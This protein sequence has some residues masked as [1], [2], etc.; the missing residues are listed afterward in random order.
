MEHRDLHVLLLQPLLEVVRPRLLELVFVLV[1]LRS[2]A[3]ACRMA[4]K[5][6]TPTI[7]FWAKSRFWG[8]VF[9]AFCLRLFWGNILNWEL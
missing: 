5:C 2:S 6:R 3:L 1:L 8:D 7:I 4:K 9:H